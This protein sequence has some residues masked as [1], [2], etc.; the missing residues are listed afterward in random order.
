M[1]GGFLFILFW[2]MMQ[3]IMRPLL[4]RITRR[5][6][7]G[8]LSILLLIGGIF[9][10]C[11]WAY[12]VLTFTHVTQGT[13]VEKHWS[14]GRRLSVG[15]FTVSYSI[16][17]RQQQPLMDRIDPIFPF[18]FAVGDPV[19]LIYN[20]RDPTQVDLLQDR[21]MKFLFGIGSLLFGGLL[22]FRAL[23]KR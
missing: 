4:Q 21:P 22:L 19:D 5:D 18:L 6:L 7:L 15:P 20:P 11:I 14:I 3:E 8:G 13:I 23:K 16:D 2:I 9:F 1:N 17:P 10:F 12:Q